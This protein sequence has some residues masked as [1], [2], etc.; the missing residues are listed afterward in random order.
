MYWVSVWN[1]DSV[2]FVCWVSLWYRDNVGLV[3]GTGTMLGYCVV[4]G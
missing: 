4:Q 2:G 1:R 3:C